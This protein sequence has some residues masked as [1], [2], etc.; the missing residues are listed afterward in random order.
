MAFFGIAQPGISSWTTVDR[1]S[2]AGGNR[3]NPTFVILMQ[4]LK[5]LYV[6]IKTLKGFGTKIKNNFFYYWR[7]F[8]VYANFSTF[9]EFHLVKRQKL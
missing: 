8:Q 4:K 3:Q 9:G 7:K 6:L 2:I 1:D 5:L